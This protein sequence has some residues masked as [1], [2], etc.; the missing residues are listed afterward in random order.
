MGPCDAF[1]LD[2]FDALYRW[3]S[4][5]IRVSGVFK[6]Y[7]DA[8]CISSIGLR[9]EAWLEASSPCRTAASLTVRNVTRPAL[10]SVDNVLPLSLT[11]KYRPT[12]Q[13]AEQF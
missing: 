7:D 12:W 2:R 13:S 6:L 4:I 11:W 8:S 3:H 1:E 9:Q 10:I 5:L